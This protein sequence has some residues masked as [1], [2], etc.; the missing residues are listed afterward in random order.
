MIEFIALDL[1]KDKDFLI[2]G[3]DAD[4]VSKLTG[5]LAPRAG[6]VNGNSL[7]LRLTTGLGGGQSHEGFQLKLTA[8]DT[9][10]K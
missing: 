6:T 2:V 5:G 7:W 4:I 1:N 8:H 10:G 3:V 9:Y